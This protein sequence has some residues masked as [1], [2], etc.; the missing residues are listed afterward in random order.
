MAQ[1]I[2]LREKSLL[3]MAAAMDCYVNDQ[4]ICKVKNGEKA[5]YEVANAI[6]AFKCNMHSNP[7]SDI[8]YLDL[9]D[10]KTVNIKI[11]QGAIK[12]AV[13]IIE[14]NAI[15]VKVP[16]ATS[17]VSNSISTGNLRTTLQTMQKSM[18]VCSSHNTATAAISSCFT[19]TQEIGNVF[20][21]DENS[22]LFAIGKG[23]IPSLNNAT[24]YSYDDIV[25]FELLEDNY[26]VIK[27]GIGRAVV[28]GILFGGVGAVVGSAT[29]KKK[30]KQ[31]CTNLM[32]KITVNNMSAPTEYIKLIS[33]TTNKNSIIYRGAYQDAQKIL[34]M[35]QLICDQRNA[36]SEEFFQNTQL[37]SAADEIRR[38]KSLMDEGIITEEEFL[39][40]KKQLLGM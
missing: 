18:D 37:Y 39:F 33:S 28:G 31:T 5:C 6:I 13:T 2:I 40:K 22:R 21:I 11:K 10:G 7:M 17:I 3:G 26:S 4:V 25:D 23:I 19:S 9:T 1:L 16:E 38:Y 29:G 34:S 15:T 24:I 35:L 12:P 27:G 30:I 32:I 8:V 20:A 36:S 14:Q